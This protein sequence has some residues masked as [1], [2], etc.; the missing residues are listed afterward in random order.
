M[1]TINVSQLVDQS[2]VGK[3]QIKIV[4]LCAL[5]SLLDGFDVQA[6]GLVAPT[7]ASDW[8]LPISSFGPVLSASFI[9]LLIGA[10]TGGVLG[11]RFGR[12]TVMICAF[13]AVG[14]S[15]L[16]TSLVETTTQL[17]V[18]RILTGF[19]IGAC[20]PNFTALTVEYTPRRR[21][22]LFVTLVFSAIPLGGVIGGYV[23]SD[24]IEWMGW[25]SV[26]VVGGIIPIAITIILI[27]SLPESIRF[28]AARGES[29]KKRIGAI[30]EKIDKQYRYEPGHSFKLPSTKSPST[31]TALFAEGRAAMTIFLWLTFFFSLSCLYLLTSWLPS[32]LTEFGWPMRQ[33]VQSIS[34]FFIGGI[35]GGL[36]VGWLIDRFG[37]YHVLAVTFFSGAIFTAVIGSLSGSILHTQAI[38]TIAG[39]AVVGAQTGTTALAAKMYPTAI[40]STGVG[41]GLGVG[42]LGAVASPLLGGFAIAA[43]WSQSALFM[44]AATPAV[45]CAAMVLMMWVTQRQPRVEN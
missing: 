37:P 33:A 16:L 45:V 24:L 6:M 9:G 42:R 12:R 32:V 26:F 13:A 15:S 23:V 2:K 8:Q 30:L 22:G 31:V 41:W 14:V 44:G 27:V 1:T 11:D 28:M 29:D 5:V 38:I 20:M 39:F 36:A 34:Y 21:Q 43:Q 40:R 18:F 19:G 4:F 25:R 35:V 10:M 3:Y 7:V 17:I